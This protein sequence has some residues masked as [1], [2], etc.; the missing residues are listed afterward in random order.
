MILL[1]TVLAMIFATTVSTQHA[2]AGPVDRDSVVAPAS[3]TSVSAQSGVSS[4]NTPGS[5][6]VP[7]WAMVEGGKPVMGGKVRL[8][9]NRNGQSRRV[10]IKGTARTAS[11]GTAVLHPVRVPSNFTVVVRGGKVGG[12]RFRGELKTRV[13]SYGAP[14]ILTVNPVTT[15]MTGYQHAHPKIKPSVA[16]KRV[17]RYLEI[18][19]FHDI[20]IDLRRSD[21]YFDGN[22][23]LR[24]IKG[25]SMD[26]LVRKTVV[27]IDH[28]GRH[29][30]NPFIDSRYRQTV[31]RSVGGGIEEVGAASIATGILDGALS[32]IGGDLANF[33]IGHVLSALGLGT[34]DPDA[35]ALA[36][37][38]S[39]LTQISAQITELEGS[40]SHLELLLAQDQYGQ[41]VQ[42]MA[43][44]QSTIDDAENNL[45]YI[46]S[47]QSSTDPKT[48]ADTKTLSDELLDEIEQDVIPI[49]SNISV[50]LSNSTGLIQAAYNEQYAAAQDKTGATYPF[51]TSDNSVAPRQVLDFYASL[52]ALQG[53]FVAEYN[54]ART[55]LSPATITNK[56][57]AFSD[58]I[59]AEVG[60]LKPLV[61]N[62]EL[63]DTTPGGKL[64]FAGEGDTLPCDFG[65]Q[66]PVHTFAATQGGQ[67]IVRTLDCG[68]EMNPETYWFFQ[69]QAQQVTDAPSDKSPQYWSSIQLDTYVPPFAS[70]YVAPGA[71]A[72]TSVTLP[73]QPRAAVLA[74]IQH[75]AS[76]YAAAGFSSPGAFLKE[77]GF[78]IG[79]ADRVWANPT[80]SPNYD[81][82]SV[83][84]GFPRCPG[85]NLSTNGTFVT[86]PT[87]NGQDPGYEGIGGL[88]VGDIP[89]GGFW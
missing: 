15:I 20:S 49:G 58:A 10:P 68:G 12:K 86:K 55:T 4:R 17:K 31:A 38:S 77:R 8:F 5:R 50:R 56:V 74:E 29:T 42:Q 45:S 27:R 44:D 69:G 2:A 48:K 65:S 16:V 76:N 33:A 73:Q 3:G 66:P 1:A 21:K 41:I 88:F 78:N 61:G 28:G 54:Q 80:T 72:S 34:S 85:F 18:P 24:R 6:L 35:A 13:R 59:T 71:S 83:T 67:S 52:Q 26:K 9:T 47:I 60:T 19:K 7:V 57:S 11:H 46:I 84:V 22:V 23:L 25:S 39:Q 32:S 36:N 75:L 63:V 30:T 62:G 37:I 53:M 43:N 70:T 87:N 51:F 14:D 81:S 79:A 40:V 82:C 89:A 64:W